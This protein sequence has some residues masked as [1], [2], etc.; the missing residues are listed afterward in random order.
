MTYKEIMAC[1]RE[2]N[3]TYDQASKLD[4]DCS[5]K[6]KEEDSPSKKSVDINKEEED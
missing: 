1:A 5:C 2:H 3:I 4:C 6:H